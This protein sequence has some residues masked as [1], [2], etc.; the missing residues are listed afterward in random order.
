MNDVER[1]RFG[2]FCLVVANPAAEAEAIAVFPAD[3][4]ERYASPTG[5]VDP[6]NGASSILFVCC[7]TVSLGFRGG[8]PKQVLR[9]R[10]L[11]LIASRAPAVSAVPNS[12][13]R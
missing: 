13:R 10:M 6:P 5:D 4:A 9:K 8:Q 11:P 2:P 1:P 3:T 12:A 7:D